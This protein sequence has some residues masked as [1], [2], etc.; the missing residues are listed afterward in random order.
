[1]RHTQSTVF[2]AM[3]E[4]RKL[5]LEA[6]LAQKATLLE[7]KKKDR[8]AEDQRILLN[9]LPNRLKT[10]KKRVI[11]LESLNVP[12]WDLVHILS[13]TSSEGCGVWTAAEQQLWHKSLAIHEGRGEASLRC[14]FNLQPG[15]STGECDIP[16]LNLEVKNIQARSAN[17]QYT[18]VSIQAGKAGR[19]GYSMWMMSAA[20]QGLFLKLPNELRLALGSGELGPGVVYKTLPS[21]TSSSLLETL[22]PSKV[23]GTM[24]VA[25]TTVN[26]YI[27]VPSADLDEAF[28]MQC[29]T[30]CSPKFML[31]RSYVLSKLLSPLPNDLT[32]KAA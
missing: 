32:N 28:S 11:D 24:N 1:M 3:L 27:T 30:K 23:F 31:K 15:S 21:D 10:L 7:I 12:T 19:H 13:S 4:K 16:E 9:Q 22:K 26:G 8:S 20:E 25:L 18:I 2:Q 5:Q 14:R 6:A 29:I 17:G